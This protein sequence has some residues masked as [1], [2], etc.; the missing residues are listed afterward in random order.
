M[1]LAY[2]DRLH[3]QLYSRPWRSPQVRRTG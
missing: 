3:P 1:W 2:D